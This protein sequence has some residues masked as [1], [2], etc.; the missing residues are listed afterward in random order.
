MKPLFLQD[1]LSKID[2]DLIKGFDN[3]IIKNVIVSPKKIKSNTMFFHRS[4]KKYTNLRLFH[5]LKNYVIVT[6]EPDDF[7]ELSNQVI[8]VKV[9]N[10]YKAY[11]QFI[12]Y[13]RGLFQIPV[14]GITGTCG[15]TTTKEMIKHILSEQY[16]VHSTYKSDN[17]AY[18][19]HRYLLGIDDETEIAVFEMGVAGPNELA[20]HCKYLQPQIRVLLNMGVYHLTGCKTPQAYFKEKARI[21]E[22]LDPIDGRLILNADDE[23]IKKIDVSHLQN[24]VYFGFSKQAD[25]LAKHVRYTDEGMTFT[26]C[27]GNQR[28]KVYVP[29]IGKHNVYN[30]L[31]AIAAT[32]QAGIKIKAAIGRLATF[33]P[34]M[35]HL[36]IRSGTGGCTVIDDTWNNSPPSMAAALQVLKDISNSKKTIAL[37]GFMVRLGETDDAIEQYAQMGQK[38]VKTGVDLLVVVGEEAKE[39]GR[40][41]LELGMGKTKVYFC[42]DAAEI[43][44]RIQPF[45]NEDTMILLKITHRVMVKP[46]F[47][48]LKNKLIL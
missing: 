5:E 25:F 3:L 21:I 41:A 1:I 23:N 44:N 33:N 2:G 11:W 8:I 16:N 20:L 22:G 35:E 19:D 39:I 14:M 42:N 15:K 24:V 10:I 30:A 28:Y 4:R 12:R 40:K 18:R 27:Y 48:D 47:I 26:L 38:V 45:L 6:E 32:F 31:A 36:Q 13:Y 29:C 46:S 9:T 43:F 17:A 34:V 37:L 7:K